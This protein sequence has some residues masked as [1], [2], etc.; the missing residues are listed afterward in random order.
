MNHKDLFSSRSNEWRTPPEIFNKLDKEF[1]FTLDPASTDENALCSYHFTLEQNGLE[2]D[3]SKQRVFCNPP[4]GGETRKWVEKCYSEVQNKCELA[5]LLIP[6]R[7]DVSYFHDFILGKAAE[8]RF[9]RSRIKYLNENGEIKQSSP[10]P[11]VIVVFKK[12]KHS[13]QYSSFNLRSVYE[14]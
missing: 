9:V 8:V 11:S 6:C 10:F 4:Y 13:T 3:W 12:G 2:Q 1:N 7:P 14:S 5:V